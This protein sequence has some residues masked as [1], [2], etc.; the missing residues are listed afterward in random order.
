MAFW[1]NYTAVANRSTTK[2]L[3]CE[4]CGKHI[5]YDVTRKI[6]GYAE[7]FATPWDKEAAARVQSIANRKCEKKLATSVN[8]VPCPHCRW[9]QKHMIVQE[10]IK[11]FRW[12]SLVGLALTLGVL[13]WQRFKAPLPLPATLP[14]FVEK[15]VGG[16]PALLGLLI[17]FTWYTLYNP[18]R[19]QKHSPSSQKK[20]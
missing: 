10:K 4:K 7:R 3:F 19:G 1:Q 5:R 13:F 6:R 14:A 17:G 20:K 15:Y 12:L 11:G 18:N 8:L 16:I 9:Y 2:T